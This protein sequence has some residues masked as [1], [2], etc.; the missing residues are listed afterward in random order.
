MTL[1]A[2]RKAKEKWD[3]AERGEVVRKFRRR[4]GI[5]LEELAQLCGISHSTLS[6]Y[7]SGERDVSAAALARLTS[8]VVNRGVDAKLAEYR[9]KQEKEKAARKAEKW[10]LPLPPDMVTLSSLMYP[11]GL[12]QYAEQC[13]QMRR[14]Y[15]SRWREVFTAFF[16]L[17]S[18]KGDLEKRLA[19]LRDLLQLETKLALN[20]SERDELKAKIEAQEGHGDE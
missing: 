10:G 18:E 16:K 13:E 20:T 1:K 14:E 7:E 5:T 17:A 6:R 9:K 8:I 12:S 15:G 3:L 2:A 19:E 11:R 4:H